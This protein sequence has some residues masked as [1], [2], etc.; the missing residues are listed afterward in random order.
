L[1]LRPFR[2][3]IYG[4]NYAPELTGVGKFTGE[5][6]KWLAERGYAIRVI[7][8]PP[9]YPMWAVGAGYSAYRYHREQLNGVDVWRCPL[10]VP[11][12]P[13]GMRRVLHLASFALSSLPVALIAGLWKPDLVLVIQPTAL[14]IPGALVLARL[15]GAKSWLHVHDFEVDVALELGL[16]KARHLIRN[17]A[18]AFE[19][20]LMRRFDHISTISQQMLSHAAA[21]L[22]ANG[23]RP[24][25]FLN[26]IDIADVYPLEYPSPLRSRMGYG[27]KDVVVLY[28][29]SM[30]AK[31]GLGLLLQAAD[32][33]R[34]CQTIRFVLCGDG[35]A[36]TRLED[37]AKRLQ[38]PNLRFLP[39]QPVGELNGLLNM[40]DIH[41]LVQRER[42]SDLLLPS[43]LTGML[44]SGRP[45]IATAAPGTAIAEMI[46]EA[47]CGEVV[48][49][50]NIEALAQTIEDLAN[51]PE[52][53]RRLGRSARGYAE[54]HFDKNKVLSEWERVLRQMLGSPEES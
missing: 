16:L 9:Y 39:L 30:G 1:D 37:D 54:R 46:K 29:G 42:A 15:S 10:W 35:A 47:R 4:I 31:Q 13:T 11:R 23:H 25:L 34:H 36:R 43:K 27:E 28:S 2:L 41:V 14:C 26:W 22:G 50:E 49:P 7:T 45:T 38:L 5:M 17:A 33:L 8:A 20:F 3:L 12:H 18:F 19:T 48:P 6:C 51:D 40:A 32:R 24:L 53:R 21:K 44:A 52:R